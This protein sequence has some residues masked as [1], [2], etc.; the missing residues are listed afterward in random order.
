[1]TDNFQAPDVGALA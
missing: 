1:M